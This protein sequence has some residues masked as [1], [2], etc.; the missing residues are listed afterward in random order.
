MLSFQSTEKHTGM[1]LR[2]VI[3]SLIRCATIAYLQRWSGVSDVHQHHDGVGDVESYRMV[4]GS[5]RFE[6]EAG[7]MDGRHSRPTPVIRLRVVETKG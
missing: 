5:A 1:L 2:R 6:P 3:V 4:G 7:E